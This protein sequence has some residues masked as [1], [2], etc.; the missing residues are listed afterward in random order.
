[1][2]TSLETGQTEGSCQAQVKNNH[3]EFSEVCI[4]KGKNHKEGGTN[5]TL[6]FK[7]ENAACR[8]TSPRSPKNQ[9]SL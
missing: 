6:S 3:Y 2:Y 9:L 7:N 5:G 1:M 8:E 4:A